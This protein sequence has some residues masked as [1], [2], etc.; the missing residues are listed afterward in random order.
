MK[1]ITEVVKQPK[2]NTNFTSV[3]YF[4]W[5]KTNKIKIVGL[6]PC[7][8]VNFSTVNTFQY[9]HEYNEFSTDSFIMVSGANFIS[10]G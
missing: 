5:L 4:F 1:I 7:G 9:S 10:Q 3:Y 8:S 6:I 2:Q